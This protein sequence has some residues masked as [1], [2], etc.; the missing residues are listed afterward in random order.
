MP[1]LDLLA[2]VYQKQ[3]KMAEAEQILME[4][5][6]RSPRVFERYEPLLDVLE[7]N[8]K[9]DEIIRVTEVLERSQSGT[10]EKIYTP[11]VFACHIRALTDKIQKTNDLRQ[12]QVLLE[13]LE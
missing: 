7:T 10:A 5:V 9:T 12:K 6:K 13:R 1:C 11:K 4:A 2:Q 3:G 8:G